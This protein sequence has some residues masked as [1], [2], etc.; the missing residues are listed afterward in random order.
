MPAR[1]AET[2]RDVPCSVLLDV[3]APNGADPS[4]SQLEQTLLIERKRMGVGGREGSAYASDHN[5]ICVTFQ[6]QRKYDLSILTQPGRVAFKIMPTGPT[7]DPSNDRPVSKASVET[8]EMYPRLAIEFA[9]PQAYN[10]FIARYVG[11]DMAI[12]ID[13]RVVFATRITDLPRDAVG[14]QLFGEQLT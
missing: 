6:T 1:A 11:R 5:T 2:N 10:R 8:F 3:S 9:R 4:A 13:G 12:I 7:F 14:V